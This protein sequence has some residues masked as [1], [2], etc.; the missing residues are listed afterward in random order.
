MSSPP[1]AKI[2]RERVLTHALELA[3]LHGPRA[4]TM[5]KIAEGL[6]VEAMSLY[7]HVANKQAILSGIVDMVFAEI[8]VPPGPWRPAMRQRAVETRDALHRHPW[9][10]GMMDSIREPGPHT[11]AHHDAVLG[12]LRQGGFDLPMAAHAFSLLDSY[13]YGFLHQELNLPFQNTEELHNM[14]EEMLAGFG[15]A[16]PHLAELMVDHALQP[17]Y[18]Y[19]NEFLYG[20]DLILDGLAIRIEK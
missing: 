18:A 6:G 13:I 15:A 7:H 12:S 9:A 4:L 3:D 10:I 19:A 11:L 8:S 17:G 20:L 2:T 14:G 16:Y 5:R 1:R